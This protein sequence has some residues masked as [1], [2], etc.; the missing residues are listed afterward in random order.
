[1]QLPVWCC[2]QRV[3]GVRRHILGS[4]HAISEYSRLGR[5]SH[6]SLLLVHL[7]DVHLCSCL[8]GGASKGPQGRQIS[9]GPQV[10]IATPGRLLDFI[11]SGELNVSKVGATTGCS[12]LLEYH[13]RQ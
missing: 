3:M 10:I 11:Q 1:M 7:S 6:P 4:Q 13:A 12:A 8:Y 9:R 5:I 2:Q